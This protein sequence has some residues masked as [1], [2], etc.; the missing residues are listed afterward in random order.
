[1][2]IDEGWA[3]G[4]IFIIAENGQQGRSALIK[5]EGALWIVTKFHEQRGADTRYPKAIVR[6][7]MAEIQE[8]P[9]AVGHTH[10]ATRPIPIA[11]LQPDCP[12]G[13]Y[14]EYEVRQLPPPPPAALN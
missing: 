5:H 12:S 11:V 6:L 7:P 13:K 3:A 1:M 4:T 2:T 9:E 10:M 8:T 14:G